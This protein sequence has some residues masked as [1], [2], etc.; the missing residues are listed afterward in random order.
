MPTRRCERIALARFLVGGYAVVFVG[1]VLIK[2]AQAQFVNPP[3]PLPPPVFNPSSPNTVPQP[4]YRP[5]TPST[6]STTPSTSSGVPLSEVTSPVNERLPRTAARSHQGT[7]VAKTRSVHRHRGRSTL[8]TYSCSYLGC[9]RTEP[10]A[11][12]CQ[13]YSRYC[14]PYGYYRPYGWYRY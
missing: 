6:P 7:S 8:V 9:V 10:W 2:H 5:V 4:S 12:P 1:C 13:Y 3:S 11:F 14:Y